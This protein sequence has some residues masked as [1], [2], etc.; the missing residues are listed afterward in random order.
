MIGVDLVPER[1][2]RA[3][4]RGVTTSSTCVRHHD[5]GEAI[6]DRTDGRGTDAVI[7]AVGMEAHGSAGAKVSA[8]ARRAASGRRRRTVDQQGRHRPAGRSLFGDR[9][10]APRRHHLDHRRLRRHGDPLPMFT[11]FD[12]QIALRMGQ[13]NVKRG[14]TD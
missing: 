8:A 10:R 2:E 4:A 7:D 3:R 9:H 14:S 5:L 1:L 13:A 6:R 11:L 12:K